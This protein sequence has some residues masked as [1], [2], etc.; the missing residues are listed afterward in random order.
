MVEVVLTSTEWL[1]SRVR[2]F[3]NTLST[4]ERSVLRFRVKG[5]KDYHSLVFILES[6]PPNST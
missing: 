2:T 3:Y 5:H 1:I 6:I 4:I